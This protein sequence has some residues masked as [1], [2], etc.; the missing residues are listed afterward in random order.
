MPEAGLNQR[1]QCA[2]GYKAHFFFYIEFL[3]IVTSCVVGHGRSSMHSLSHTYLEHMRQVCVCVCV[4]VSQNFPNIGGCCELKT[5]LVGSK[6]T[7]NS[8]QTRHDLVPSKGMVGTLRVDQ[9]DRSVASTPLTSCY[10]VGH[11]I[12]LQET[13]TLTII[14]KFRAG[15]IRFA[16]TVYTCEYIQERFSPECAR[17]QILPSF[18]RMLAPCILGWVTRGWWWRRPRVSVEAIIHID[19]P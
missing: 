2:R 6:G 11:S 19:I 4:C 15:L 17:H 7:W 5:L 9:N 8:K 13:R 18:Y 3:S 16:Y 1:L 12:S 10:L 14:T